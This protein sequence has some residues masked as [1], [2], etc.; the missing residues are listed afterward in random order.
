M[1]QISLATAVMAA[2]AGVSGII[3]KPVTVMRAYYLFAQ[4]VNHTSTHDTCRR[5]S[6]FS[7]SL[8]DTVDFRTEVPNQIKLNHPSSH[9][10]H[11]W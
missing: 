7:L 1:I 10:V 9:N 6:V 8:V 11:V 4:S 2:L 5:H 3:S